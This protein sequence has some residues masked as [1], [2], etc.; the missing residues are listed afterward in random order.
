M[1]TKSLIEEF[2]YSLFM[3]FESSGQAPES[4][5]ESSTNVPPG[6]HFVIE[7][8]TIKPVTRQKD[9]YPIVKDNYVIGMKDR[10][11][12]QALWRHGKLIGVHILDHNFRPLR[13]GDMEDL[14]SN[15]HTWNNNKKVW[16]V[17]S[18]TTQ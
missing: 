9:A 17:N 10:G 16:I 11:V 8:G 6:I 4:T 2:V 14:H 15:N 3:Y 7:N 13:S 1:S 5:A 18:R 12:N